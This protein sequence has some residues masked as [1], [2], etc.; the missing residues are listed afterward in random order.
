MTEH[1]LRA[2]ERATRAP[3]YRVSF[4]HPDGASDTLPPLTDPPLPHRRA[5]A[6]L[7]RLA[8]IAPHYGFTHIDLTRP[9]TPNTPPPPPP[10]VTP[11]PAPNASL[12]RA[13]ATLDLEDVDLSLLVNPGAILDAQAP[14]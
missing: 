10:N 8:T 2:L 6:L 4:R 14:D 12:R 7:K 5:T 11:A 1:D 13:L 3:A 9:D